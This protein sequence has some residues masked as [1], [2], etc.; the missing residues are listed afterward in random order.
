VYY[1]IGPLGREAFYICA[2]IIF[3]NAGRAYSVFALYGRVF[4]WEGEFAR[5][6]LVA[7]GSRGGGSHHLF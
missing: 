2:R 5:W 6:S 3:F 4:F 7:S 1:E